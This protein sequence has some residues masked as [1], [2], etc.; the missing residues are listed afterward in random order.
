MQQFIKLIKKDTR[1]SCVKQPSS[2]FILQK[3]IKKKSY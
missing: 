3:H 1:F 2:G